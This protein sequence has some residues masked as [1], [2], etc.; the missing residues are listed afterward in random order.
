MR[1]TWVVTLITA[2]MMVQ[3]S[4]CATYRE[5]DSVTVI[6][7]L[8]VHS[9][10]AV[11]AAGNILLS[12]NGWP[13]Q[14]WQSLGL[15]RVSVSKRSVFDADPT[16]AQVDR[17]LRERAMDL[18]ADAVVDIHYTSGIGWATWGYLEARGTAVRFVG[19]VTTM[20]GRVVM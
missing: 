6:S 19:A 17:V 4:G 1:W 2:L 16:V 20:P 8:A 13:E 5:S 10:H 12:E 14:P 15:I 18:G 7:P 11:S 9:G 3:V